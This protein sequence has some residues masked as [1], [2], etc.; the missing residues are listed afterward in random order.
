MINIVGKRFWF[1]L[2]SA[3]VVV[4]GI[5][6]LIVDPLQLGIEFQAGS[7]L[8]ATFAPTV[9]KSQ[10]SQALAEIGYGAGQAVVRQSGSDYIVD[11][12]ELSD[13][14]QADLRAQL[15]AKL[16]TFDDKGIQ[17]VSPATATETTRNA[18]I[19]VA[20]SAIA[21]LIYISWAFRR[22]P[23]PIR[24]G[25]IAIISLLHCILVTMGVFAILASLNSW[26]VDLLFVSAILTVVGYSVNDTIVVF[27]RIREAVRR[28][29]AMDFE[30]LVNNSLVETMGRSL[31][32][33][34]CTLFAA[35]T[36]LLFV[37]SALQNL[38]VVLL[39]GVT[40]GTYGSIFIAAP[41]LIVWNKGEWGRFIGRRP[42][43]AR[44][45]AGR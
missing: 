30:M 16:G 31:N 14:Q 9:S 21:M 10:I 44:P 8:T 29:P 35:I 33:G 17:R 40:V 6:T 42:A 3:L 11:L 12:P 45:S 28:Y 25:T 20:I 39:V 43:P 22:M 18:A 15:T 19:A 36:L 2:A 5:V 26:R 37:G 24:W 7:E 1:F 38:V 41:L 13:A 34:M 4:A 23:N 27:D 32:T